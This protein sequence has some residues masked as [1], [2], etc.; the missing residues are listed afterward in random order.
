MDYLLGHL[1][2]PSS[3]IVFGERFDILLLDQTIL[4]AV[5][6][7]TKGPDHEASEKERSD[8]E[9][10]LKFYGTLRWAFFT[11]GRKWT[12]LK[13]QAPKGIQ[14]VAERKNLII[15]RATEEAAAAFFDVLKTDHFVA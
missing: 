3:H 15:G 7:E 9:A 2:W 10:R 1:G 8:F 5:N 13:L 11:N 4:P 6:I 12:R 14:R